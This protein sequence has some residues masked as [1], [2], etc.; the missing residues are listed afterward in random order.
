MNSM[1]QYLVLHRPNPGLHVVC[2]NCAAEATPCKRQRGKNAPLSPKHQC[3]MHPH[4]LGSTLNGHAAQAKHL[5]ENVN[6]FSVYL[7]TVQLSMKSYHPRP[8]E[9]TPPNEHADSK[10]SPLT[11]AIVK[12]QGI[13]RRAL[14]LKV[15]ASASAP[16]STPSLAV[17]GIY[18]RPAKML[19]HT[20]T[21]VL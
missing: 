1:R 15:A 17:W 19:L 7:I 12:L 5:F 4:R 8:G 21:F 6:D 11:V 9:H 16:C 18:F 3:R 13:G 20:H 2:L 10:Q 14:P